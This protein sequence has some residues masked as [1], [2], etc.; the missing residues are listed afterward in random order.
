M[1][2]RFG[3]NLRD[4][5]SL[6]DIICFMG[7]YDVFSAA[8]AARHF[9]GIFVSGFSFAA[10]YYGLP[11]IG[12]I[13][14]SDIVAFVQRLRLMLPTHH[15]VVDIDDGYGDPEIA[16]H[17][18]T[19]L[20]QVGAS[21]VILEDQKRPRRS[22]HMDGK[23]ILELDEF[24]I[25]L[26]RVLDTRRDMVVSA[27]TD[28]QDNG[29]RI[30]RAEAFDDAGADAILVDG[31]ENLGLISQLSH[32]VSKPLMFNQIYGGKSPP[33]T[34]SELRHADVSLVNY[35]TPCLFAAQDAIEQTM[36]HLKHN[37]GAFPEH[38]AVN[39]GR[40]NRALNENMQRRSAGSAALLAS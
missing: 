34:L 3:Q 38:G 40:C 36:I 37:D 12:F 17:V 5:M 22:G 4:E 39:L 32:R 7:V 16:A 23:Q 8:Q 6:R 27:R 9:D 21:A 28:A 14:W 11:D 29:E 26:T 15:I 1:T 10:S 19:A 35:S 20:E 31:L 13:C 2:H 25:K 18:V 33:C 24:L 30:R